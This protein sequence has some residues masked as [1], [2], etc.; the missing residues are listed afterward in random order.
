MLQ[1]IGLSNPGEVDHVIKGGLILLDPIPHPFKICADRSS[2]LNSMVQTK[3]Y[4]I[5]CL[6][7][8][9]FSRLCP[10][11]VWHDLGLALQPPNTLS[12]QHQFAVWFTIHRMP[13]TVWQNHPLCKTPALPGC[14]RSVATCPGCARAPPWTHGPPCCTPTWP[15]LTTGANG[16]LPSRC[17]GGERSKGNLRGC[18]LRV[19]FF[20]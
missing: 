3:T 8:V 1:L 20:R 12:I 14:P 2:Q 9:I 11:V 4:V 19:D 10:L 15:D 6:S 17:P 7:S 16:W 13:F 5:F 18:L